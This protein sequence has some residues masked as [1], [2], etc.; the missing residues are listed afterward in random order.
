VNPVLSIAP[1][2]VVAGRSARVTVRAV[3]GATVT[4]TAG[5][6][7]TATADS[8]GEARL[9]IKP[10]KNTRV[11]ARVTATGCAA[12]DSAARTVAVRSS[13]TL[14]VRRTRGHRYVLS[15]VVKPAAAGRVR[16]YATTAS[17]RTRLIA[18]A[19]IN[20]RTGRWSATHVF[21]TTKRVRVVAK[22]DRTTTNA[23][24]AS[25]KRRIG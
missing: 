4:L 23:A 3:P 10:T 24:G 20:R 5:R 15:G 22:V 6:T 14:R 7:L 21:A 17:G 25:P 12:A 16:L 11:S 19:R 2:T 9:T 8:R 1:A 13:V 18:Q